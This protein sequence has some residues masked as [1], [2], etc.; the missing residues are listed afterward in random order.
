MY[1]NLGEETREFLKDKPE[2]EG[3]YFCTR[4]YKGDPFNSDFRN[5]KTTLEQFL[6]IADKVK[7]DS[8]F[9][10]QEI[11]DTL[12]IK[13]VDGSTA[14][15]HEYDGAEYW[16]YNASLSVAEEEEFTLKDAYIDEERYYYA[17]F[18]P[19]SEEYKKWEKEYYGE[20]YE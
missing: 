6:K 2:V 14:Y 4:S 12:V 1:T 7:Y 13:F 15:R 10:A 3:I 20:D 11:N 16:D 18:G 5:C 8:G 9:G 19:D 17:T